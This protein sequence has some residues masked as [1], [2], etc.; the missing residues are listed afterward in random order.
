MFASFHKHMLIMEITASNQLTQL[1]LNPMVTQLTKLQLIKI[2]TLSLLLQLQLLPIKLLNYKSKFKVKLKLKQR[3]K[4]KLKLKLKQNSETTQQNSKKLLR[5]LNHT[6]KNTP[7]PM[8]SQTQSFQNHMIS[9]T[10]RDSTSQAQSVTKVPADLATLSHSHK[11]L[12]QDLSSST[13]RM[14]QSFPHSIL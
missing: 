7:M 9:Q 5:K 6:L 2:R 4:L 3:L 11:L 13:V 1:K 14:F 10:S 12:N 8:I